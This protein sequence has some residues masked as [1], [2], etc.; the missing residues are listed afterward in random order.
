MIDQISVVICA[1]DDAR[2]DSLLEGVGTL[3]A[4]PVPPREVIVVI[5]NNRSLFDRARATLEGA[6]VIENTGADGAGGAKNTGIRAASGS[7]VAFLDDDAVPSPQWLPGLAE[8]YRR[9]D[10]AGV[11]GSA[12]P[13][14]STTRPAW[15]PREFDWVVGCSY[16][17]M[18]ETT[19][20]VRNLFGCN[21][22]F[23]RELLDALDGFR[24][25]YVCEETELCIRLGQRW[26][27]MKLI[28]V[29]EAKVL[30][31][32][33][34]NRTKLRRFLWRCY[35]EGGRKA[36]V[37]KLVGTGAALATEYQYT[38]EVLPVGVRRGILEFVREGDVDGLARAAVIVAGLAT[39][40]AG[41]LVAR[42]SP[43]KTT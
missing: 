20:E 24:M 1:F 40:S 4:Q 8:M 36:V 35:F 2:W 43:A 16:L 30:H 15:F 42:L 7:I 23:R 19:Q 9:R 29:P 32:V 27:E 17:G 10:V 34:E 25:G 37:S 6:L 5:D 13:V 21:M 22:S 18:P 33:P 11:G 39:T 12:E 38:R 28:Y 26:P 41:Y 14:W 31:K 3:A